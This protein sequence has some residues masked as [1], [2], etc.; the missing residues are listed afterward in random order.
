MQELDLQTI[1]TL[2]AAV[3]VV[4]GVIMSVFS[5]LT[6]TRNFNNS[7]KA[8]LFLQLSEKAAE[9][10]FINKIF[11]FSGWTWSDANEFNTK[12]ATDVDAFPVFVS[13]S[14][15]FDSMG[16]LVRNG[17]TETKF[18]P[19]M[20][21]ISLVQFWESIFPIVKDLEARW[22]SPGLYDNVEYLYHE[23]IKHGYYRTSITWTSSKESQ[24]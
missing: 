23:A 9:E 12:Y 5:I 22:G 19:R 10:D 15:Y 17:L 18:M 2:V 1:S 8:Q 6:S 3:S 13:I 21:A 24:T 20:M 4:V 16:T 14:T 7:R 11:E